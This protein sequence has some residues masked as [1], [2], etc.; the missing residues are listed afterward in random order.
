M[1]PGDAEGV[2]ILWTL[3]VYIYIW[4]YSNTY[5]Y[6][7]YIFILY[8]LYIYYIIYMLFIFY[9]Y[10]YMYIYIYIL[11]TPWRHWQPPWRMRMKMRCLIQC[12]NQLHNSKAFQT[13]LCCKWRLCRLCLEIRAN[14]NCKVR[15]AWNL[16]DFI[17]GV[18]DVKSIVMKI[19][20]LVLT[21]Y[22]Q[23]LFVCLKVG[24]YMCLTCIL[25]EA[26]SSHLRIGR[27]P[28]EK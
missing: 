21:C 13:C 7:V 10:I 20:L 19:L 2:V 28:K 25:P 12:R 6:I 24:I 3:G 27:N 8:I 1:V 11:Y 14:K 18:R 15:G 17:I 16:H 5:I 22:L 4:I 23:C 9:C 26:N